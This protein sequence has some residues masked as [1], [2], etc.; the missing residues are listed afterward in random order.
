MA[1][2]LVN[3]QDPPDADYV[4]D[5]LL[6]HNYLPCQK[7][8]AE[9]LPPIFQSTSLTV[10]AANKLAASKLRKHKIYQGYD[11]VEYKLTRF[12]SVSR[13]CSIPHPA[14]YVRLAL[15]IYKNWD[16]LDY[17]SMNRHSMIRPRQHGDGRIIVME[18][19]G[20]SSTKT[21]MNLNDAFG[22]RFVVHTDIANCFPSIYTH[23]IPWALVT[24]STAK[25]E[26]GNP[27]MWYNRLDT[28][29]RRLKRNET[30]GV[31]IG[32]ATSNIMF[33]AI[34]ARV[35]QALEKQFVFRRFID[36]YSAYCKTEEEAQ[37]F[38]RR[39]SEELALY[40]L[41]LGIEKT[42]VFR[43]PQA[44]S[45]DWTTRLSVALPRGRRVSAK[46]AVD[47]LDLAVRLAPQW[48]N[49]SVLKY[50][51]KSLCGQKLDSVA[52]QSVLEYA[53]TLAFHEPVLLPLIETLLSRR[54]KDSACSYSVQLQQIAQENARLRRSDGM[55]WA[56]YYLYKYGLRLE[57][58]TVDEVLKSRDC[59]GLL[60][61]YYSGNKRQ[62]TEVS[63]FATSLD[64][65]DL[66]LLDQY[67]ILLY[68]LFR[69]G[70]IVSS[71]ADENAFEIMKSEGVSFVK[72]R[73]T[74]P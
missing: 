43:L 13:C 11:A 58:D 28:A 71:Y 38:I 25:K 49:G 27:N 64:P 68:E 52:I 29:A 3:G 7:P 48:P 12:N 10:E 54:Q 31:A 1:F 57:K 73:E 44:L 60:L 9:E 8:A 35:D 69:D 74:V 30:Q 2:R 34:L 5:A 53:L 39:L 70:S 33:E 18:G 24:M 16:K 20:T 6:R 42:E 45:D 47:Y 15:C 23:A 41:V 63:K 55:V 65:S 36:D 62:K 40:K 26:S 67:W 46:A 50:A 19:Y 61:L 4:L 14:A 17:V 37:C 59:L 72:A 56:L 51:L 21:A 22:C 32:P 66:Y